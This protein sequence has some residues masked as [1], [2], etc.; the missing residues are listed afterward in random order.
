[1]LEAWSAPRQRVRHDPIQ[2]GSVSFQSSV[3]TTIA[4]CGASL[5]FCSGGDDF[6]YGKC[7]AETPQAANSASLGRRIFMPN[8]LAALAKAPR[9][10]SPAGISGLGEGESTNPNHNLN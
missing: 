2:P 1:M 4:S 10:S 3:P 8:S 6:G 9:C 7:S 5:G